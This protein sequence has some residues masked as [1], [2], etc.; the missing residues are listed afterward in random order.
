M[1]S[2]KTQA[3]LEPGFYGRRPCC[4]DDFEPQPGLALGNIVADV[5]IL[6][7]DLAAKWAVQD[8]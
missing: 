4:I 7:P 6:D 2:A 8:D 1:A 5:R 3:R